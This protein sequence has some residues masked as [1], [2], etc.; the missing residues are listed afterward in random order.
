MAEIEMVN[1]ENFET[2]VMKSPI[3][4]LVDFW[5]ATCV[6]CRSLSVILEKFIQTAKG[7]LKIVK[8][9]AEECPG[10]AG[11]LGVRGVPTLILFKNGK[12]VGTR[13]GVLLPPE[14]RKWIESCLS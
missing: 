8:V 4:T 5:T 10:L 2:E 7:S 3:P 14:L 9:N 6:P 13:T 12:A 1:E 11:R